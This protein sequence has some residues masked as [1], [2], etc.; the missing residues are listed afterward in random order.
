MS[1]PRYFFWLADQAFGGLL[2]AWLI[3]LPLLVFV[4]AALIIAT[5]RHRLTLSNIAWSLSPIAVPIALL[6][7]G[8]VFRRTGLD[9]DLKMTWQAY[10]VYGLWL[11]QIPV[12]AVAIWRAKHAR[13]L[14]ADAAAFISHYSF[15]AAFVA[16]MSVTDD[17]L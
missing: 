4:G 15:W 17:W 7:W 13:L 6:M 10:A 2:Y 8:V 11:A 12:A 14:A 1:K 9:A 16:G 3:S 5:R